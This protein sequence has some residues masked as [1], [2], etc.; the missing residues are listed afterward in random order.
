MDFRTDI[1]PLKDKLFRMALGITMQREEAEDV[2]QEVM[3]KL[4]N[5]RDR[6]QQI[7]NI[8]A[9]AITITRNQALDHTRSAAAKVV[10]LD[11]ERHAVT[12][13]TVNPYDGIYAKE[14]IRRIGVLM[15]QL[16]EKQRTCMR[17]RDFEGKNYREIAEIMGITEEQVKISIYRARKYMKE[18]FSFAD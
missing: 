1:L 6:W 2:V 13:R 14:N 9:Y 8:E 5:Q 7:D 12:E 11:A 15:A 3:M 10:S 17:L 16:P 4:W 18:H